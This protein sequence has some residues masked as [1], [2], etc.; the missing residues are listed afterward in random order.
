[1]PLQSLLLVDI[2]ADESVI[3]IVVFIALLLLNVVILILVI[4]YDRKLDAMAED[5]DHPR[6][7]L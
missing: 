4:E 2:G 5:D 3:K 1:M 6:K 7:S